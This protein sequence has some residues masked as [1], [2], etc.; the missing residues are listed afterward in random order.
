VTNCAGLRALENQLLT[1]DSC[2]VLNF[3][4]VVIDTQCCSRKQL[5]ISLTITKVQTL[6]N[7]SSLIR[8]IQSDPKV[9]QPI[10]PLLEKIFTHYAGG[11]FDTVCWYNYFPPTRHRCWRDLDSIMYTLSRV[12]TLFV[13]RCFFFF[14]RSTCFYS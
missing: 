9:T 4:Q 13:T 8:V 6:L 1:D 10:N 11:N 2:Y 12:R 14:V 3:A 7:S 5:S